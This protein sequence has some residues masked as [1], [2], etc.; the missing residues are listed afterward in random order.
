MFSW[1]GSNEE[2]SV[3]KS[4]RLCDI[5]LS[6]IDDEQ[7]TLLTFFER[8][9]NTTYNNNIGV[10]PVTEC[11]KTI[12]IYSLKSTRNKVNRSVGKYNLNA[13]ERSNASSDGYGSAVRSNEIVDAREFL[14]F[15]DGPLQEQLT[16]GGSGAPKNY[17]VR[18]VVADYKNADYGNPAKHESTNPIFSKFNN[19]EG[20]DFLSKIADYI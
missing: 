20:S 4:K 18:L 17:T 10:L 14:V 15:P 12:S 2:Y 11:M 1:T 7:Q 13:Q 8:W 9:F 19:D 3:P 5:N 6:F 16:Y